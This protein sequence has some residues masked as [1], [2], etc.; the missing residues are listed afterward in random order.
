MDR[1]I[2]LLPFAPSVI[3]LWIGYRQTDPQLDRQTNIW[4]YR[5]PMEIKT[6][7][8]KNYFINLSSLT[9]EGDSC[10]ID[11]D[12]SSLPDEGDSC[13]IDNDL[14]SLTDEGD[15]SSIDN[16]LSSLTNEEE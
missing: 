1:S 16:D 4:I 13:S 10:S 3:V 8:F 7:I 9:D 5:A 14:S 15:S 6:F 2:Y 12:L 11:N